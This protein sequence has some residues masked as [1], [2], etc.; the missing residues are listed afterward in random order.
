MQE[1]KEPLFDAL[2]CVGQNIVVFEAMVES[3]RWNTEKMA[4]SCEGGF[5]NATDV[6]D[7]LVR[8]G[9]PF[10]TAHGVAAQCVRLAIDTKRKSIEELSLSELKTISPLFENDLFERIS[11][12]ECMKA[13]KTTGGPS[14]EQV[15]KQIDLLM[16]FCADKC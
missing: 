13:R 8:K 14:P 16:S 2:D 9:M 6:A 5:L 10:R 3:A 7:Y 15:E 4:A 11:P 12:I 1:D